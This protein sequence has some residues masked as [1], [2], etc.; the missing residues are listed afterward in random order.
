MWE[1]LKGNSLYDFKVMIQDHHPNSTVRFASSVAGQQGKSRHIMVLHWPHYN[2]LSYIG[3]MS[4]FHYNSSQKFDFEK[5]Y[6][7]LKGFFSKPLLSKIHDKLSTTTFENAE[8]II[9]EEV[10]FSEHLAEPLF[11]HH[12]LN[13]LNEADT[14]E[15]FRQLTGDKTLMKFY[16]RVYQMLN[17]SKN[18]FSWHPDTDS[19]KRFALTVNISPTHFEGGDLWIRHKPTGHIEKIHNSGNGDAVLF[20]IDENYEHCVQPVHGDHPKYAVSGWYFDRDHGQG[21][22]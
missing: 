22:K 3:S 14:L 5:N 13:L 11:M 17:G 20:L 19:G 8:K 2:F 10:F 15:Y 9:S 4:I 12:L 7:I 16:G 18:S 21:S 1:K 6:V